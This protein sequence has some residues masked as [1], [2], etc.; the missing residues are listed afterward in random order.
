MATLG[1][2]QALDK[3]LYIVSRPVAT[4]TRAR[5]STLIA[6][7]PFAE[8]EDEEIRYLYEREEDEYVDLQLSPTQTSRSSSLTSL[9]SISSSSILPQ[10]EQPHTP[11]TPKPD[12]RI[13]P[14]STPPLAPG[15]PSSS[16]SS[17][18][19]SPLGFI[20]HSNMTNKEATVTVN[21]KAAPTLGEGKITP[22][23]VNAW[24]LGCLQ[25]FRDR[26]I[27]DDKQVMKASNGIANEIVRDWYLND[28]DRYDS[29]TWADFLEAIRARFLPKGW[30]S[31]IRSQIIAAKQTPP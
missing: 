10:K 22:A 30:A 14:P 19:A 7:F 27:D 23:V 24:E 26:D 29:M 8:L 25:Y 2:Y 11:T 4:R 6:P 13:Y 31:A 1:A 16:T 28:Y 17:S 15:S 18:S 21:V 9:V 5:V 3:D 12:K 20:I